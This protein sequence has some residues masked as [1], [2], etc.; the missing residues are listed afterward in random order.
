LTRQPSRLHCDITR[1]PTGACSLV[2]LAAR[3]ELHPL[4]NDAFAWHTHMAVHFTCPSCRGPVT[5]DDCQAGWT[6]VCPRCHKFVPVPACDHYEVLRVSPNADDRV[7]Q[8]AYRLLATKVHPDRRPGDPDAAEQ[9]KLLNEAY[10]VLSDPR[11]RRDYDSKRTAAE[12]ARVVAQPRQP[13]PKGEPGHGWN[14]TESKKDSSTGAD[15]AQVLLGTIALVST[16]LALLISLIG[17][18]LTFVTPLQANPYL[19]F[20]TEVRERLGWI[21]AFGIVGLLLSLGPLI[22]L[23]RGHRRTRL[24]SRAS[25]NTPWWTGMV[26]LALILYCLITFVWFLSLLDTESDSSSGGPA[27]L[28]PR[29]QHVSRE[30]AIQKM[31]DFRSDVRRIRAF[32]SGWMALYWLAILSAY[33][34]RRAAERKPASS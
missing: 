29:F 25:E 9:M 31:V 12:R 32:S 19:D 24:A 3:W 16:S 10:E 21:P 33:Q 27:L 4:K 8:A 26:A 11:K 15:R 23:A 14:S 22:L 1:R 17:N 2:S 34:I 6:V 13:M 7:I 18:L 30:P 28:G 5:I 20:D